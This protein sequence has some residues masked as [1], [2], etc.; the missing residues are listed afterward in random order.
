[1]IIIGKNQKVKQIAVSVVSPQS[2]ISLEP[3]G[4][5]E[6]YLSIPSGT[7]GIKAGTFPQICNE[8]AIVTLT[9]L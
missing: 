4:Q 7:E 1:V 3:G 9:G 8:E 5:M 6:M 2:S